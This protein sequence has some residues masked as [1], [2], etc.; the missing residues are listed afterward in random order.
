MN[1]LDLHLDNEIYY[2]MYS[3]GKIQEK[4]FQLRSEH[5]YPLGASA[6]IKRLE[7]VQAYPGVLEKWNNSCPTLGDAIAVYPLPY[8]SVRLL[9]G[10]PR[11]WDYLAKSPLRD[12]VIELRGNSYDDLG[13]YHIP[14]TKR[15]REKEKFK[16]EIFSYFTISAEERE[17]CLLNR[18]YP[19]LTLLAFNNSAK[20]L[21][22]SRL[23]E[24]DYLIGVRENYPDWV[25]L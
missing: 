10:N 6:F 3:E 4:L 18:P 16:E 13:G 21:G 11:L 17:V 24:S 2:K 20:V 1:P 19:Y 25:S 8:G 12:G 7:A 22:V 9:V 23:D 15:I 5:R 14:G